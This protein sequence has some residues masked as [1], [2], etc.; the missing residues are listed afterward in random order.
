MARRPR[1]DRAAE[2]PARAGPLSGKGRGK[3]AAPV[4][5]PATPWRRQPG[6]LLR[7]QPAAGPCLTLGDVAMVLVVE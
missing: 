7:R 3:A 4:P 6:G 5:K 1:H 2:D